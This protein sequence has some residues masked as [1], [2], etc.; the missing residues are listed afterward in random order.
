[1]NH[2]ENVCQWSCVAG[3]VRREKAMVGDIEI[4]ILPN[5][6][7][8]VLNRL[9][10]LLNM[11]VVKQAL[12]GD[13][14]QVRWG[15]T[16]RGM[17]YQ[18]MLVEVFLCD[19]HNRGYQQWL[20]TGGRNK[21][22]Y[23]MSRLKDCKSPVRFSGGYGW[24]V[25]YESK[26][27]DFNFELGYARLG[28]LHIPDEFTL[29]HLLGMK[30]IMPQYRDTNA[31]RVSLEPWVYCPDADELVAMYVPELKQKRMF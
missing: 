2:L 22:T 21:N 10:V 30:P 19:M 3:S 1:M 16:Y 15:Q 12:Y 27:P 23:V 17:V 6:S 5:A 28:K 9:D 18:S 25:S 7:S 14:Q 8:A 31:Y 24:H 20:R 26:H 29:Y 13:K 11:G 4:V